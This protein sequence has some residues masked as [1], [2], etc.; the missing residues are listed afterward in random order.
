[1]GFGVG[2]LG[3]C[4]KKCRNGNDSTRVLMEWEFHQL[5]ESAIAMEYIFVEPNKGINT[6][7]NQ[8][9]SFPF[10]SF[11]PNQT[12]PEFFV[13]RSHCSSPGV[14]VYEQVGI[15]SQSRAFFNCCWGK[16]HQSIVSWVYSYY[17]MWL[18]FLVSWVWS[19]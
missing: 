13:T 7:W 17:N 8:F 16:T 19:F 11:T 5:K 14:G 12:A 6:F 4:F 15:R 3:K 2:I 9:L 1:M 18:F 10:H